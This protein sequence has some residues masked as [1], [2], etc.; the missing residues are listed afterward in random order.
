MADISLDNL[1]ALPT[2]EVIQTLDF[3]AILAR[4]KVE[5]VGRMPA[6]G[7][8][9]DVMDLETDPGAVLLEEASYSEV[10]L[11]ARGNDI[12][13]QRY[14][15]FAS[16]SA[17]DH[18]GAFY[19][20]VRLLGE[21]DTRFKARII[22]AIMGRSTGGTAPRYRGVALGVST[23]V[24]DAKVY[25]EG[26]DPTVKIAVFAADNNGV[27]DAPLLASVLAAVTADDVRMVNDTIEVRSAVVAVQ[28]IVADVTLLPDTPTELLVSIAAS[29]PGQ[30]IAESGL[31]RNLMLD[32][33]KAKLVVAGVH[34]ASI[35]TPS[36]NVVVPPYQAVRIGTVTLNYA[37]RD[38]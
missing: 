11:R 18:L 15:Y 22:L 30:W 21:S 28:N 19:D 14:I 16:G 37:G 31:G 9:Y 26:F 32:W 27:A 35:T 5:F 4:K 20:C 6:Y 38:F 17:L 23:R 12:A 36:A 25:T 24:A 1:S 33:I 7:I 29:L 10:L 13:R 2:P 8:D 34:A 3:E